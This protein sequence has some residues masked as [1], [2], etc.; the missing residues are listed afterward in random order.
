MKS[1]IIACF[2]ML[3]GVAM[4]SAQYQ[5]SVK[6]VT[7]ETV[8]IS[9]VGYGKKA[10]IAVT[11]AELSAVKTLLFVGFPD[12]KYSIPL[13]Q[14]DRLSVEKKFNNF[15]DDFYGKGYRNFIESTVIV[16]PFGKNSLKQKCVTVDVRVRVKQLRVY[17]E[18]NDIIRKF[19]L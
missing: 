3:T 2:L 11:D 6:E 8:T 7:G 9:C 15:F 10:K 18:N 14:D 16:T 4:S 19:G 5:A 12:S 1:I 13:I 17:L